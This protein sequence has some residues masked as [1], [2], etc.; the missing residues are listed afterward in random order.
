[1]K[2][3][4]TPS[5]DLPKNYGNARLLIFLLM[6]LLYPTGGY[7]AVL[8]TGSSTAN[9]HP[10][11]KSIQY[12]RASS[13]R[14]EVGLEAGLLFPPTR[15]AMTVNYSRVYRNLRLSLRI[16]ASWVSLA[17]NFSDAAKE[18][19]YTERF[20][21]TNAQLSE[22]NLSLPEVSYYFQEKYF[23][24][25]SPILRATQ[26]TA[27]YGTTNGNR[28]QFDST[29]LSMGLQGTAGIRFEGRLKLELN[30]GFHFPLSSIG[31]ASLAYTQTSS[32]TTADFSDQEIDSIL[33]SLQ[34]YAKELSEGITLQF[35][36]RG[37]W[38][39]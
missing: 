25:L 7:S 22:V 5:Y 10:K 36:V 26:C 13:K 4:H 38:E 21:E 3:E 11:E 1:M 28:L 31:S 30:S 15:P 18:S 14:S 17:K 6:L 37:I 19:N 23:I 34:P 39:L 12:P 9:S 24:A 35:G 8:R 29:G 20:S 32:L 16:Q 2:S 27:V 33:N